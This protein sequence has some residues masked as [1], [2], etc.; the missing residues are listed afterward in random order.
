[1]L[2]KRHHPET[3]TEALRGA[4]DASPMPRRRVARLA[5]ID[6]AQLCRFSHGKARLPSD[7]VDRLCEVLGLRVVGPEPDVDLP[8]P[9][10][11]EP[12]GAGISGTED[13][14]VDPPDQAAAEAEALHGLRIVW[15]DGRGRAMRGA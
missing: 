1:M 5:G 11:G 3:L 4:I 14:G 13:P 12:D 10:A 7:A 6:A 15:A 8:E 2:P 9:E